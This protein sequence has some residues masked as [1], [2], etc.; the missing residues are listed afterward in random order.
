MGSFASPRFRQPNEEKEMSKILSMIV[1]AMFAAVSVNA[2]AQDKKKEDKPAMEK[3]G[4]EKGKK[5]AKG[6]EKK[7]TEAKKDE[8][9]DAAK[10]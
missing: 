4:A 6:A 1:A 3:K 10:K 2:V 9:K 7:K 8:K 5:E